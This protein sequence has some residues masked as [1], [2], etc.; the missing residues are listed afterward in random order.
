MEAFVT[1][2]VIFIFYIEMFISRG[3]DLEAGKG[4]QVYEAVVN[5]AKAL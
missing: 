4:A 5:A 2:I 1:L 3:A